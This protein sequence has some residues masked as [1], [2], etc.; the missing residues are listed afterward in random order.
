[1]SPKKVYWLGQLDP[2]C[3]VCGRP[4]DGTMYDVALGPG[5]PWGNIC[6]RCF[7]EYGCSLGTGFGQEYKLQKDGR[8]LKVKG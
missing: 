8:W 5:A 7:V 1:M 3:Q 2:N 6:K 4:L